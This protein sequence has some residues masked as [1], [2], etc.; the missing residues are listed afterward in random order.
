MKTF[1]LRTV[2]TAALVLLLSV[3]LG[4]SAPA[5]APVPDAAALYGKAVREARAR[6]ALQSWFAFGETSAELPVFDPGPQQGKLETIPGPW[7]GHSAVHIF[8]GALTAKP[9]NLSA[10]GSTVVFWLRV[11]DWEKVDRKGYKRSNGGVM[12]VGSGWY[13][14]WRVIVTPGTGTISLG[15]GNEGDLRVSVSAPGCL[16][17]DRWQH[18]AITW[19]GRAARLFIDGALQS[20]GPAAIPYTPPTV[21]P[22]QL[23]IGECSYGVG[24]LD[25]DIADIG[26]FEDVLPDDLIRQLGNPTAT[27]AADLSARLKQAAA[28][29]AEG[30]PDREEALRNRYRA[31][32][33]IPEGGESEYAL[34]NVRCVARLAIADSFVRE[35]RYDEALRLYGALAE[36]A[37]APHHYRARAW[38]AKADTFRKQKLYSR[39][40]LEYEAIRDAFT[41]RDENCRV[42][43]IQ[44]LE[45]VSGLADGA[46][47]RDVRQRCIERL[48]RPEPT[49]FVSPSGDDANSGTHD[50]PFRT[51]ER[52]RDALRALKAAGPLPVG[53]VAVVLAGGVYRRDRSFRLGAEDSGT[54][55]APILYCSASGERAVLRGGR[56]VTGFEPLSASRGLERIP[57]SARAHVLQADLRA[58]GVADLGTFHRRGYSHKPDKPAHLELFFRNLPMPL[59][60]WPN[61]TD[62]LSERFTTVKDVIGEHMDDFVGKD[63]DRTNG[64][65]YG[66]PRHKNWM[67]EPEVWLYGYWARMYAGSYL[68]VK[69]IDPDTQQLRI[70]E[71]L[72]PYKGFIKG[73]PYYA[74]N[75]LCELDSPGE[76][77]VDREDG[78][79][80]FWPPQPIRDGDVLVSELEEPF[81]ELTDV[82][83]VAFRGLTLEAG[84]FHGAVISG[85]EDVTLAGCV[86]RNLGVS[87]V[88]IDGGRNHTVVGC[89]I[90]YPGAGGV[91]MK[92]GDLKTLEPAGHLVENCHIHHFDRWN[93][94]GY[95]AGVIQD[96]VGTRVSHCLI[97]DGPQQALLVS[98][99]DH[100]LEYSEIHDTCHEVGEMGS[101]YMYGSRHV[102]GDR[103]QLVRFNYWHDLPWNETY[104]S[105]AYTGRHALH[106]DHMNGDITLYG[107]VFQRCYNKSGV[108]FSGGPDNTVENNVFIDCSVA[109]NLH[110]RSWVYEKVNKEPR[111]VLDGF[112]A[113]MKVDQ[114]PWSARYPQLQHYP[115]KA[116]DLSVFLTGNVVARNIAYECGTFLQGAQ[117]THDLARIEHNWRAGDPGFRNASSGDFRLES[118]APAVV[119][120]GFDPLPVDRIGL[121]NDP[122]RATWPVVHPA[123]HHENILISVS[124]VNKKHPTCR[125]LP[126]E[127]PIVIDGTLTPAEWGGLQIQQ[128]VVLQRDPTDRPTKSLPSYAWLRRDSDFLY[129]GLRH[130]V[131]PDVP[132]Q[133]ADSFW[134]RDM[135][136]VII[137]GKQGV[138][139]GGWWLDER[140]HGPLFYLVGDFQGNFDSISI[141]ELPAERAQRLRRAVEYAADS[142]E[143]GIWTC[144]WKIP[145]ALMC[146]DPQQTRQ[147]NFN[148]GV[149]KLGGNPDLPDGTELTGND[150]WTVWSGCHGANWQVW[151]AG[152]LI[153]KPE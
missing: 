56:A 64:F 142:S 113:D 9:F 40:A 124:L 81:L 43:A 2:G 45:D 79:L 141:D 103:G 49:F 147:C 48:L 31:L 28:V 115:A 102:L 7:P 98:H 94:G 20:E 21:G 137:E 116:E 126:L 16:R 136:E 52:A 95:Q 12:A 47:Y 134:A 119:T 129:I 140:P 146:I 75:V 109:I 101:Y 86:L 65:V 57:E 69:A 33:A 5:G 37:D 149:H 153:L 13:D 63:I 148:I 59:A 88:R 90:E 114:P 76:W 72:P 8:H 67:S 117:K 150:Q 17:R 143:K 27:L 6:P 66:D 1:P 145:L 23:R 24:V 41:G 92:G 104:K 22:D 106:I 51:L 127:A 110:D 4:L 118:G 60:R 11:H 34:G 133:S 61:Q 15:I 85:G 50:S 120:S 39:A 3:G 55:E 42:E 25:F 71:P 93:R 135:A 91:F 73:A 121:Y 38:F 128:A 111:F 125:A 29:R 35:K 77:Y 83:H 97:H 53:G 105:F 130:K 44:R 46:P 151:N 123:G 89:D 74:V 84:R 26:F 122:L 139:T 62:K 138:G 96:G 107:N 144:E 14:G 100:V 30:E 87:G 10:D 68:P 152:R 108:F 32:A 54:A 131:N 82:S 18:V 36:N 58:A 78:I 19:D 80:Y 132:L 112:L 70:E 99:N